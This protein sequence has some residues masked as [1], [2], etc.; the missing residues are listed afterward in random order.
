MA[1]AAPKSERGECDVI[2]DPAM[3]EGQWS[4]ALLGELAESANRDEFVA[5]LER[6]QVEETGHLVRLQSLLHGLE[7]NRPLASG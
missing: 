4:R 6:L 5:F 2:L 1:E 3:A 7:A